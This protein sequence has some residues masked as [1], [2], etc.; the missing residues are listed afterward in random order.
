MHPEPLDRL[1]RSGGWAAAVAAGG[2]GGSPSR[3]HRRQFQAPSKG[4]F[5]P[6][7][8]IHAPGAGR[9]PVGAHVC[10]ARGLSCHSCDPA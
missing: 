8:S 5:L 3:A 6:A 2:F 4:S 9:R 10:P 1:T 7:A